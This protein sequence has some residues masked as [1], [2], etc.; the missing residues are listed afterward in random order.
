MTLNW[1]RAYTP[2]HTVWDTQGSLTCIFT[3]WAAGKE[4][5]LLWKLEPLWFQ[6]GDLAI[7]YRTRSP[8]ITDG[9]CSLQYTPADCRG[10]SHMICL[11]SQTDR[12]R[13]ELSLIQGR[14]VECRYDVSNT[15]PPR[16][17]YLSNDFWLIS[18]TQCTN[19]TV[20]CPSAPPSDFVVCRPERWNVSTDCMIEWPYGRTIRTSYKFLRLE[21]H[22]YAPLKWESLRID[23][24]KREQYHNALSVHAD[25]VVDPA[26][27]LTLIALPTDS[28][29]ITS[30]YLV[31]PIV[32]I[33]VIVVC[34]VFVVCFC[35]GRKRLCFAKRSRPV[36]AAP[37]MIPLLPLT[38]AAT[39]SPPE[40][41]DSGPAVSMSV[42]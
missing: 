40:I 35:Y 15:A 30:R 7:R 29:Q 20:R 34:I 26:A 36:L 31:P 42:R 13:C 18:V 32:I 22:Y 17:E 6:D 12:N 11:V 23:D 27:D 24:I 10:S 9:A 25:L 21:P 3:L 28:G 41:A 33:I 14:T 39:S 8:I 1:Y 5:H 19:I 38:R 37:P 16:L 4:K 2:V